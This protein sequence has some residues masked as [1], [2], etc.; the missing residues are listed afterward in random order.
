[1]AQQDF[2]GRAMTETNEET[3]K[4]YNAMVAELKNHPE[5]MAKASAMWMQKSFT[6]IDRNNHSG[7]S[8]GKVSAKELEAFGTKCNMVEDLFLGYM[9]SHYKDISGLSTQ[10]PDNTQITQDEIAGHVAR[11]RAGKK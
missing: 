6:A 4:T 2:A 1:M 10:V 8:D 9:M 11:V 7:F 3:G 5:L